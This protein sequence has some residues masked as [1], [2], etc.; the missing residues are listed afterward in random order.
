M[1]EGEKTIIEYIPIFLSYC[2]EKG[3]SENTRINYKRYLNKLTE[4]L[5]SVRKENITPYELTTADILQYRDYLSTN[6]N[7]KGNVLRAISQNYYL[8]GLRVFLSFFSKK[9]IGCISYDKVELLTNLERRNISF[10]PTLKQIKEFLNSPDGNTKNGLRDQAIIE[11]ITSTGLKVSELT[12]LDR[13]DITS[14][15]LDL[16][17]VLNY[18][19]ARNDKEKALFIN[20]HYRSKNTGRRLTARSIE[21][22]VGKH[23][24]KIRLPSLISPEILRWSFVKCMLSSQDDIKVALPKEHLSLFQTY[25]SYEKR[26]EILEEMTNDNSWFNVEKAIRQEITWLKSKVFVQRDFENDKPPFLNEDFLLR[27]IAILIVSGIIYGAEIK[28]KQGNDFW[29][30]CKNSEKSELKDHGGRWHKTMMK[31]IF[32]YFR[33]ITSDIVVE[34]MLRYGRADIGVKLPGD[35]L[36]FEVGTISSFFKLWYNFSTMKNITMIII[37]SGDYLIEFKT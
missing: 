4:W 7:N 24:K 10:S 1:A 8:I 11:L 30:N 13:N 14:I 27:K 18:L 20:Y 5:K 26:D 28:V 36:Y 9:S 25:Y 21:R 6:R 22:I 35:S 2:K 19:R 17:L 23:A 33:N 37:P 31:S 29:N 12:K 3:L 16:P 34:P 32:N 15:G